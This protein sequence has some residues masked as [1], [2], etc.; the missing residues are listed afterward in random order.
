MKMDAMNY[1]QGCR[2]PAEEW[3]WLNRVGCFEN[4]ELR[5]YVSPFPPVD[6]MRNVSGLV[7][8]R[9][10]ASH[11][12]DFFLALSAASPKPLQE[13]RTVL[14]FG[15]GCGRLARMFKGHPGAVFGC[16]VDSRHVRWIKDNL[17]YMQAMVTSVR[18]PLP[19]LDNQF[20]AIISIS[21]FT[22]LNERSQNEFLAELNRICAPNGCLFLTV[23]GGRAL[24]RA[25]EEPPIRAM[26]DVDED[27]FRKA[28]DEFSQGTHAFILQ[29]GHLT[30]IGD[31]GKNAVAD[32]PISEPFE[33]GITFIPEAY[34]RKNWRPWFEVL[35]YRPGALHD[36]QDLV[37][38]RP[39]K[40][41][42]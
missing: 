29:H 42:K 36:F 16:D 13:F 31:V 1:A 17:L 12:A 2:L 39:R 5:E 24:R 6:L 8:E 15:C 19:Y 38:I 18:P 37:V 3:A 27:R 23:H 32:K 26:I 41:E 40:S 34:V 33:Y 10:F 11:G 14:D 21:V 28:R 9:D 7:N 4:P 22:H 30:T 20:E 25:I 35:D